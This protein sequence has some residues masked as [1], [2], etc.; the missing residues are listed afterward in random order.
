MKIE[1]LPIAENQNSTLSQMR[2]DGAFFCFV[3]EDGHRP[4]KIAGET[5][6]PEGVYKVKQRTYGGFYERYRA[7]HGHAF[8][9]E[10]ENVPGFADILIHTGNTKEDTRGCLLVADQAGRLGPDYV[11][12]AG[13]S[14][15]AYTRLYAAIL[16][17]F[18][19]GEVVE[20]EVCRK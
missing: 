2:V 19:M 20:V 17:A 9:I 13:T 5:R 8:A 15:P 18:T 4:V 1:V 10:L 16:R 14:T 3:I 12:T 11:G 7:R 6:I